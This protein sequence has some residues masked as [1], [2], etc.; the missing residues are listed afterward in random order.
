MPTQ[1]ARYTPLGY[2]LW[3][4]NGS[5]ANSFVTALTSGTF[6]FT[7]SYVSRV[8]VSSDT[9]IRYSLSGV[10]PTSGQG[11]PLAAGTILTVDTDP[12]QF[13]WITQGALGNVYAE[14]VGA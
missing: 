1:T 11:L 13:R 7:A 2:G 12:R 5:T 10:S 4:S 6:S 3:A 14:F 8:Y 9:A